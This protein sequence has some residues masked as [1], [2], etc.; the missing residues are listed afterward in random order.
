MGAV[1]AKVHIIPSAASGRSRRLAGTEITRPAP[2]PWQA[3]VAKRED[4]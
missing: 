4:R 2:K 1:P 3:I